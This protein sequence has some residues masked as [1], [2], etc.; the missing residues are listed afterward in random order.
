MLKAH[1]QHL[2]ELLDQLDCSLELACLDGSFDSLGRQVVLLI[3]VAGTTVQ[4]GDA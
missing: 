3:P 4:G 1:E 2:T